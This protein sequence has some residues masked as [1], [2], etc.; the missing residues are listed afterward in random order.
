MK[1]GLKI[2]SSVLGIVIILGLIFFI[3][4]YNRV[5]NNERPIFCIKN[6]AGTIL[7]GG[8]VEFF[9]L[10]YKVIDFHT[11]AGFDDIKIGS[12]FMEYNDFNEEIQKYEKEFE[13]ELNKNKEYV[14]NLLDE[15]IEGKR[16]NSRKVWTV[17]MFCLWY[18]LYVEGKSISELEFK[19]DFNKNGDMCRLA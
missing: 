19:S 8:T 14:I 1:K 3:V 5:K 7:D 15:H 10:G 6:P 18:E 17:F 9:G 11:I 16:D 2:I 12:W 13:E 4:D